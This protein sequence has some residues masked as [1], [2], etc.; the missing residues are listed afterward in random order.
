MNSLEKVPLNGYS[1]LIVD[2]DPVFRKLVVEC[3][4]KLGA[5][6]IDAKNGQ[7]ALS[8]FT[9]NQFN[10]VIAGLNMPNING[11]E[12]LRKVL[13]IDDSMPFIV[14]SNNNKVDEA[15]N[16]LRIGAIDYL[17]KPIKNM[18]QIES[19]VMEALNL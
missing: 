6:V 14:I 12:L 7:Q 10:L 13:D 18:N 8:A 3:L 19:A 4:L 1:I 17:V 16:A 11:L 2:D 15:L 5:T 9:T